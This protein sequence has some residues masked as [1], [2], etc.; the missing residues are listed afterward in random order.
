MRYGLGETIDHYEVLEA[1][2]EGAYAET[3]KARDT[4]SG[5]VVLIKSPN[6]L[7]F[8]DPHVYQRFAREAEIAQ[9]L[10]HPG[11]QQSLDLHADGDAYIVLEYVEGRTLRLEMAEHE[12]GV[13]VPVAIDWGTQLAR[14]I[15]YLHAQGITHRDLKPENVLVD[16]EGHLKIV[17]FGTALLTG[18]RRLTWRHLSESV[19]TPDY[20][21]P[22]QIQGER[23]GPR[24]DIY[25]WGIMLYEM[26]TGHVP[27]D[28]D[29]FLAVMA[30]HLQ[31]TPAPIRRSRPDV[32][33]GFEAVVLKAMR[34]FPDNRYLSA[35][36]LLADLG[37]LDT[38]DPASFDQWPE[39]PMG[40]MAAARSGPQL[41]G[42]MALIAL[43]FVAAIVLI[44]LFTVVTKR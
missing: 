24:S 13:P 20:M 35:D 33:L 2:G 7:M 12:H 36:E 1:L 5:R 11:L 34:R 16:G 32:P 4:K 19:G 40:G 42:F 27:F 17:D 22:E 23:G 41:W 21:S 14:A 44:I 29:N 15:A 3:Y 28:G 8:A 37:D 39:P 43:G 10:N 9:R 31:G 18:A 6:P 38:L 26:L 30:G 25:S